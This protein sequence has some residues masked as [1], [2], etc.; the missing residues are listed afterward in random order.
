MDNLLIII[1]VGF[2]FLWPTDSRLTRPRFDSVEG[3]GS[4]VVGKE[5]LR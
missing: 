4:G 2:G 5:T 1:R 3:L